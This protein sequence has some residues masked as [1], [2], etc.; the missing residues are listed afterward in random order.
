MIPKLIHQIWFQG[1]DQLPSKYVS[2]VESVIAAN[3]DWKHIKWDQDSIRP[4]V[5]ALGAQYLL[6]YDSF[7]L[8]HQKVDYGRYA[9]LYT[10]GGVS[11]DID[12]RAIRSLDNTPSLSTSNFIVSWNSAKNFVNNATIFVSEKNPLM[13]QF[14]GSITANCP[15]VGGDFACIQNTTG[16]TAF[17]KFVQDHLSSITIL[18]NSYFEPCS[19]HD[20]YCELG[21]NAIV[22]HQHA[23]SWLSPV[24]K[25]CAS[26]Y[27]FCVQYKWW[28]GAIVILIILYLI[29][30]K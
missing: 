15:M 18:D 26:A 24:F 28:I 22:D 8:L 9:I 1:W 16:P 3:P 14:L 10:Y 4:V 6:V 2:N 7:K 17:N 21:P 27:F 23:G 13:L 12:A 19:G 20:K 11:V 30:R 29:F 25:Q 5:A